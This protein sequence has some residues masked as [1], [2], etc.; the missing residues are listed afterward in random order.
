MLDLKPFPSVGG[1]LGVLCSEKSG[2][3]FKPLLDTRGEREVAFY[4]KVYGDQRST[5][6]KEG[7]AADLSPFIGLSAFIPRFFG[8]VKNVD[9]PKDLSKTSSISSGYLVLENLVD[10]MNHPSVL[11]VKVGLRTYGSSASPEKAAAEE[12]K[13]PLQKTIGYRIVGMSVWDGESI[14][15]YDRSFGLSFTDPDTV[16]KGFEEFLCGIKGSLRVNLAKLFLERLCIIEKWFM[17]QREFLFFGSSLL[18]IYDGDRHNSF[19]RVDVRLI[20]FAHTELSNGARDEGFLV[21][22]KNVCKAFERIIIETR[23]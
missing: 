9:E 13:Y 15:K 5:T 19:S 20:D 18:F 14:R 7:A 16:Y 8:T 4:S 6:G 21:G 3:L 11:D 10:S 12:R 1:H 22:L 17:W 23:I 2:Q